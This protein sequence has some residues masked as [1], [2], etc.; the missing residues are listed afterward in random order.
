MGM[1]LQ[2]NSLISSLLLPAGV[3]ICF[4]IPHWSVSDESGIPLK[5]TERNTP[6]PDQYRR[7][8]DTSLGDSSS[9]ETP[10][11]E[12][13]LERSGRSVAGIFF[14]SFFCIGSKTGIRNAMDVRIQLNMGL[15]IETLLRKSSIQILKFSDLVLL[16]ILTCTIQY[17][18][19]GT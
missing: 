11:S 5:N 17:C 18:A 1:P 3:P 6:A 10:A 2:P 7:R 9:R 19:S 15:V 14:E 16:V 12:S 13:R 4:T 8:E